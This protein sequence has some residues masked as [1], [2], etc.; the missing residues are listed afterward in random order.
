EQFLELNAELSKLWPS[1]TEVKGGLEDA[2]HWNGKKNK[3]K[4]LER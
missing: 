2:D 3:L 1:I 4:F